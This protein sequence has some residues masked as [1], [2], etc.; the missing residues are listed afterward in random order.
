MFYLFQSSAFNCV[1]GSYGFDACFKKKKRHLNSHTRFSNSRPTVETASA[2]GEQSDSQC[3]AKENAKWSN[4]QVLYFRAGH[5]RMI[6]E[7]VKSRVTLYHKKKEKK[8]SRVL[9]SPDT[10]P[11][12]TTRSSTEESNLHLE[13]SHNN[14]FLSVLTIESKPHLCVNGAARASVL[15]S[16]CPLRFFF[17]FDDLT[18]KDFHRTT[19]NAIQL[20][21]SALHG[22]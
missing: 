13:L 18:H 3:V 22:S 16:A 19:L 11:L 10:R 9:T 7:T 8:N 14:V 12:N 15:C 5:C 21:N 2:A 17:F 1:V 20:Q 6:A 4:A